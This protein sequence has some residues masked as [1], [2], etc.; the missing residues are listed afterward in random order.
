MAPTSEGI[1]GM[2][3]P[4]FRKGGAIKGVLRQPLGRLTK[5]LEVEL[6]PKVA[7]SWP[8]LEKTRY[9]SAGGFPGRENIPTSDDGALQRL[10][11]GVQ[12][13]LG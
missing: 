4:V 6:T 8:L 3:L 13:H 12:G 10:M 1:S 9:G 11:P 2:L 5:G 7:N